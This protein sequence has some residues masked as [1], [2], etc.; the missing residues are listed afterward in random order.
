MGDRIE[1]IRARAAKATPGP[2][3]WFGNTDTRHTYLATIRWGRYLVMSFHRWGMNG[4]QPMFAEGRRLDPK[5]DDGTSMCRFARGERMVKAEFLGRYE[6]APDAT[7]RDDDRVYRADLV[8]F[9][10]PDAEFIAHARADVDEL[11][12]EVDRLR[13]ALRT[14]HVDAL[15]EAARHAEEKAADPTTPANVAWDWRGTAEWLRRRN[16]PREVPQ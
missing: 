1:E 14:A 2:W 10:N 6:V 15:R 5:Y 11:L 16:A 9:R 8:G 13:Q 4:A 3:G 12:A 7:S